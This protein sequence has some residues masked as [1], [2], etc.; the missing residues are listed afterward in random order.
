L[1]GWLICWF[2][3]IDV[4]VY[5]LVEVPASNIFVLFYSLWR[6]KTL[7]YLER[8]NI[9]VKNSDCKLVD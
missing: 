2:M 5:C 7:P 6:F 8:K 4:D 1:E 3:I 9:V